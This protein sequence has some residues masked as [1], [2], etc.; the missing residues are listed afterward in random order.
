MNPAP[1]GSTRT[2]TS[3]RTAARRAATASRR[4]DRSSEVSA[5]AA[6]ST[7]MNVPRITTPV[8]AK[9]VATGMR[10]D[11]GR[12]DA[13]RPCLPDPPEG[14]DR[15]VVADV[16]VATHEPVELVDRLQ[17]RRDVAGAIAVGSLAVMDKRQFHRAVRRRES[18]R[19][20]ALCPCRA[21]DDRRLAWTGVESGGDERQSGG[22]RRTARDADRDEMQPQVVDGGVTSKLDRVRRAAPDRLAE[23]G[24]R[25]WRAVGTVAAH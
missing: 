23:P 4:A 24:V 18:R 8:D 9:V 21:G 17:D 13:A 1:S 14:V 11:H 5:A 6:G 7:L 10:A 20:A 2:P 19:R 3:P 25:R 22:R 16:V 12:V 15:E